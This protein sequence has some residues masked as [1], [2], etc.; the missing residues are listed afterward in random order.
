MQMEHDCDIEQ[1]FDKERARSTL[2]SNNAADRETVGRQKRKPQDESAERGLVS[3]A[4]RTKP[5]KAKWMRW[6]Q[7]GLRDTWKL[8]VFAL[9]SQQK[10]AN[11][12]QNQEKAN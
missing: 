2:S 12:V 5:N 9:A 8:R 10:P 1:V 3:D 11:D 7:A 6:W 4:S